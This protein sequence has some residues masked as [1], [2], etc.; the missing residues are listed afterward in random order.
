MS[1]N[2]YLDLISGHLDGCNSEI[3]EKRL[4]QHLQGCEYCRTLLAQMQ[5]NDFLLS[6]N[7]VEPPADLSSRIMNAVRKEPKK[8]TK[9]RFFS[10]FAA[11]GLA[12]AAL[13]ALV[14]FGKTALPSF[15]SAD[16]AAE[17]AA[18]PYAM[19]DSEITPEYILDC[20]ESDFRDKDVQYSIDAP[21]EGQGDKNLAPTQSV[22]ESPNTDDKRHYTGIPSSTDYGIAY[23]DS[24]TVS[25]VSG[26]YG[27]HA[28]DGALLE[29]PT[30]VIYGAD[31]AD[32]P[33][34]SLAHI[35]P[36][37][38]PSLASTNMASDGTFYQRFFSVLPAE[39]GLPLSSL[40]DAPNFCLR[41]YSIGYDGFV[42]IM[43]AAIGTY[44]ASAYF[45]TDVDAGET[46]LIILI[47]T[48]E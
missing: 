41:R 29:V 15:T 34:L 19:D 36:S 32:F 30:L 39:L 13:L 42:A 6:D 12:T 7:T 2:E 1:C 22:T 10:S 47:Q 9:K 37:A 26:I 4:Q 38:A 27:I 11:A 43:E 31:E 3:E 35:L 5:E 21:A 8:T 46:C 17:A 18:E 24:T 44:E 48:E 25:G 28:A 45:P 23:S 16:S 40:P 33:Q 20:A 14:F